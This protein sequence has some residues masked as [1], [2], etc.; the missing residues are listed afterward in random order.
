MESP[1]EVKAEKKEKKEKKDKK[2]KKKKK[3]K[4]GSESEKAEESVSDDD[5]D[6]TWESRRTTRVIANLTKKVTESEASNEDILEFLQEAQ[7]KFGLDHDMLHFIALCGLF[8]PSHN[9][10]K[11]W[12][13]HEKVFMDFVKTEGKIGIDHFMQALVL[14]FI[15]KYNEP[16][17]KYAATFMK[18]LHDDNILNERFLIDWYDKTVRLDKESNL[19]D[20]KAEKKFRDLVEKFIEWLRSA[21]SDSDSS[22]DSSSD[23]DKEQKNDEEEDK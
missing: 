19:Y 18:K 7:V 20:K 13:K 10:I 4:D 17:G 16:M 21:D 11:N 3:E 15:R 14:Y 6:I 23:D 2:E 5:E 9:I 22:G 12:D 1:T 8:P